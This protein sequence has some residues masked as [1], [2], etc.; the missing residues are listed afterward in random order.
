MVKIIIGLAVTMFLVMALVVASLFVGAVRSG[1]YSAPAPTPPPAPIMTAE[2]KAAIQKLMDGWVK[3]HVVEDYHANAYAVHATVGKAWPGTTKETKETVAMSLIGW[4]DSQGI[5]VDLVR[6]ESATTGND[7]ATFS[8][9]TGL[10][11][12]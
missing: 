8:K 1:G 9:V 4:A 7:V 12:R 5:K 2:R 6:F 11:V 10:S 3:L